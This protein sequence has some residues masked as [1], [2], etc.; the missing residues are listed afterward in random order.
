MLIKFSISETSDLFVR[1]Y[2]SVMLHNFTESDDTDYVGWA[3]VL[4]SGGNNFVTR[5][6]VP[7]FTI[8]ADILNT[9]Y[10]TGKIDLSTYS[11]IDCDS[12]TLGVDPE[13]IEQMIANMCDYDEDE[14]EENFGGEFI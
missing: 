5:I 13:I 2:A 11:D 4:M 6:R 7:N 3:I 12:C 1:E 9:L 8:G 14:D 10:E